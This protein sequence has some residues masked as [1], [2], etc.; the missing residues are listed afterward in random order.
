[1]EK[2]ICNICNYIYDPAIGDFDGGISPGMSFE[3]LPED[4]ACPICGV[5][6][7]DFSVYNPKPV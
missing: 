1:M 5:G 7:K 4:W 2:Y 3:S 6:K